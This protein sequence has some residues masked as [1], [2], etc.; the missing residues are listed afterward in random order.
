MHHCFNLNTRKMQ[1]LGS[2]SSPL[3]LSPRSKYTL[4]PKLK[5]K[6]TSTSTSVQAHAQVQAQIQVQAQA[7]VEVQAFH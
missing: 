1:K 5:S 4:R 6:C 3:V 7:Q 2:L